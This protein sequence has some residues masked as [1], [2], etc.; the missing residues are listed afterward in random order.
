MEGGL[1]SLAEC[2]C[3]D[4]LGE[5]VAGALEV[6]GAGRIVEWPILQFLAVVEGP[7]VPGPR[8]ALRVTALS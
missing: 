6:A 2:V 1:L 3:I 5:E 8:P 4:A 7:V